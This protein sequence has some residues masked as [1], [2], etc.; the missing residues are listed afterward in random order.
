M[1]E[2]LLQFIWQFQYFNKNELYV[3]QGE[4]LSIVY[5]GQHNTNQ[6]PDF[7][8][9]KI[10]IGATT[11][12]GNV[13]LH[14]CSS[15]WLKH[16]HALDK[17]FANIILHEV[18]EHDVEITDNKGTVLPALSLKNLVPKMLLQRFEN[19]MA[20]QHFFNR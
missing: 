9:A 13:E 7:L 14:I 6:G 4:K 19:L 15:D 5:P 20:S 3:E 18:W 17:N 8:N 1:T 16:H 10:I 11:L 2:R 12:A